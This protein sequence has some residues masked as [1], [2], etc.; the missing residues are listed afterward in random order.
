[1]QNIFANF[2]NLFIVCN[3]TVLLFTTVCNLFTS[4]NFLKKVDLKLTFIKLHFVISFVLFD[5]FLQLYF[6]VF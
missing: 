2:L 3:S 5:K 4:L 6:R 1:M